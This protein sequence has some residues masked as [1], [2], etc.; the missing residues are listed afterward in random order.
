MEELIRNLRP[1]RNEKYY[2]LLITFINIINHDIDAKMRLSVEDILGFV[3]ISRPTFYSYYKNAEDFYVDLVVI[4]GILWPD[5]M[6]KKNEEMEESDYMK[7][8]FSLKMGV[9]M[10]NFKK[11]SA[12]YPKIMEPWN[13]FFDHTVINLS[14]WY[15]GRFNMDKTKAV[16]T[17]RFVINELCLHD[18]IYYRDI[19]AYK[20]LLFQQKTA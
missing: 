8:A 18:D 20:N 15:V 4:L 9:L 10:S 12:K 1:N 3:K 7:M 16:Q 2:E 17:A 5:Y 13:R 19:E 6:T 11:I 14:Q